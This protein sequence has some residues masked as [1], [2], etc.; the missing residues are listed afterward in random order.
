MEHQLWERWRKMAWE[1]EMGNNGG[2][3]VRNGIEVGAL[4]DEINGSI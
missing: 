4:G 1:K 2:K 3:I